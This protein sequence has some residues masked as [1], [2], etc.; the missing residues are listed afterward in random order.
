M[1]QHGRIKNGRKGKTIGLGT[2]QWW[3]RLGEV[4]LDSTRATG[5]NM[6]GGALFHMVPHGGLVTLR[7]CQNP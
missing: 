1:V 3:P 4:G 6:Q 5:Q 7:I 2:N